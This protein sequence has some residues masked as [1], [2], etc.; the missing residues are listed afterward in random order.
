MLRGMG[1]CLL[2][3]F[4]VC[5]PECASMPVWG[6]VHAYAHSCTW[7]YFQNHLS[8]LKGDVTAPFRAVGCLNLGSVKQHMRK[9][10]SRLARVTFHGSRCQRNK[11]KTLS[12]HHQALHLA[13]PE[14]QKTCHFWKSGECDVSLR[15]GFFLLSSIPLCVSPQLTDSQGWEFVLVETEYIFCLLGYTWCVL[16]SLPLD[17]TDT[18]RFS[19]AVSRW[20]RRATSLCAQVCFCACT[21]P[22]CSLYA[23]HGGRTCV[24][25]H[26]CE[27]LLLYFSVCDIWG[28]A[29]KANK[30][31]MPGIRPWPLLKLHRQAERLI[32]Q[33][34]SHR[35]DGFHTN[36]QQTVKVTSNRV[37]CQ[38][39]RQAGHTFSLPLSPSLCVCLSLSL[40]L[41]S[42][43]YLSLSL[44]LPPL[45]SSVMP[46]CDTSEIFVLSL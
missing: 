4:C 2:V 8:D 45:T 35:C 31:V 33:T 28:F 46:Q 39:G 42:L 24:C 43:L 27:C 1:E 12:S 3:G 30:S 19:L 29:P 11:K 14:I 16:S 13:R 20:W 40:L 5:V 18:L 32:N 41:S 36:R 34:A 22:T 9:G 26:V 7:K 38:P 25:P 6:Y 15:K 17:S 23:Y 10:A 37:N 44:P 21:A